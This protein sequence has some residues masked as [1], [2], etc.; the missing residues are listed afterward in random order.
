MLC[1]KMPAKVKPWRPR[2]SFWSIW[3]RAHEVPI[4][5]RPFGNLILGYEPLQNDSALA[6]E[7][8]NFSK[9]HGVLH[10][11]SRVAAA[12]PDRQLGQARQARGDHTCPDGT[13][14]ALPPPCLRSPS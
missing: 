10:S 5:F 12:L 14:C 3:I 6:L 4:L 1:R 2:P 7:G 9:A 11:G 13:Y 8:L